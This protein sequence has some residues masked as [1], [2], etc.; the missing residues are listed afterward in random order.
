MPPT[1]GTQHTMLTFILPLKCSSIYV[2]GVVYTPHFESTVTKRHMQIVLLSELCLRMTEI[3]L[4]KMNSSAK[5]EL[6]LY[7]RK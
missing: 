1:V 6:W 4:L 3:H 2:P 5:V 7:F